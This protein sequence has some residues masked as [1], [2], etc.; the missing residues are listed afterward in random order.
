M[1]FAGPLRYLPPLSLKRCAAIFAGF[2]LALFSH[3][4]CVIGAIGSDSNI[5]FIDFNV[6]RRSIAGQS[7]VPSARTRRRRRVGTGLG[8]V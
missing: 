5:V 4:F 8:G 2:L 3:Q 7:R 6:I 1:V